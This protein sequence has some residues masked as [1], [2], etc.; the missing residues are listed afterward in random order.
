MKTPTGDVFP[1]AP[2]VGGPAVTEA[3]FFAAVRCRCGAQTWRV[4]R[5]ACYAATDRRLLCRACG[6]FLDVTVPGW[7]K[8]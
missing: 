8:A 7:K 2:V 5:P 3:A 4:L 1:A 6:H